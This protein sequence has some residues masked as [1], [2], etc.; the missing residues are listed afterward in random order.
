MKNLHFS[1][2]VFINYAL[3]LSLSVFP[4]E[5][6]T[7]FEAGIEIAAPVEGLRPVLAAFAFTSIVP[8]PIS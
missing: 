4:A 6:L 5:N 3:T 1:V 8:K 2:Q 7:C